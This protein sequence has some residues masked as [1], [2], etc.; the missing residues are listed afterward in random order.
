MKLAGPSNGHNDG[1]ITVVVGGARSGKSCVAEQLAAELNLPVT[2]IATAQVRDAEFA[3]R[4]AAHQ[5][6]RPLKWKLLEIDVDL[7]G[8]LAKS[9][10]PGHCV[11]ID[12]LTLWLS[13]LL[14]PIQDKRPRYDWASQIDRLISGLERCVGSIIIVSSEVGMGVIPMRA[15]TRQYVDAL[16]QLNQRVTA[17]ADRVI[18]TVVGIPVELKR[19]KK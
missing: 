14:C 11:L 6:R 15:A 9:D 5:R 16:G 7:A 10:A 13:N 3:K 1:S 8:A 12:C 19:S 17:L 18:L 4:I 2:Y